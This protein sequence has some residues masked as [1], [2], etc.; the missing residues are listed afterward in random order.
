[1]LLAVLAVAYSCQ[2][3][4]NVFSGTE[5][6]TWTLEGRESEMLMQMLA[7]AKLPVDAQRPIP[8]YRLGYRGFEVHCADQ[9]Y[10]VYNHAMLEQRLLRTGLRQEIVSKAVAA[11][12]TSEVSRLQKMRRSFRTSSEAEVENSTNSNPE[13]QCTPPV[14]GSDTKTVYDPNNDCN[15]CFVSSCSQNNC[16]N[17]GNDIATNTFA[18]PGRGSGHKWQENTCD[19]IRTAATSDGLVWAGTTL[20]KVQPTKGHYVAMLIWPDTNFHW[21][22][23]DS[24][25]AGYWS[26]KPGQTPVRNVDNNGKKITDP[27]KSDFS[28]WSQFCGYMTTVPSNSTIN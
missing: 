21:I 6:P 28:P 25:P 15:G 10:V 23:F 3:T 12:V 4:L 18:Q 9:D 22:R 8:W 5:D 11:H 16:Y 20:P 7:K 26:H 27:S 2:V 17:Y 24:V 14:R 13:A 19:S 1:V